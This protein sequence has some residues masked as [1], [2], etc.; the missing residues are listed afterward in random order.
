MDRVFR[1]SDRWKQKERRGH[2][3][4]IRQPKFWAKN[5]WIRLY[6]VKCTK[7]IR[8]GVQFTMKMLQFIL[9]VLHGREGN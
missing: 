6:N 3:L 7:K 8:L 9:K 5:F 1:Y 2:D 4:N